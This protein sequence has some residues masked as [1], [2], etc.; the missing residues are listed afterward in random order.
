MPNG[1][2]QPDSDLRG[3]HPR[4]RAI[5]LQLPEDGLGRRHLQLTGLLD[6]DALGDSIA[7]DYREAL[8]TSPHAEA[9]RIELQAERLGVLT[10]AVG[11]HQD[12]IPD[13]LRLSPGVHYEPIGHRHAG[14]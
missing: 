6:F 10:I 5:V 3:G 8:A 12:L 2:S 14:D 4:R 11:E 1:R 7:H 13:A 9:A